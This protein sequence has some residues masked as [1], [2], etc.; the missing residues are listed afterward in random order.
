[1]NKDKFQEILNKDI[2][3][4]TD[5]EKEALKKILKELKESSFRG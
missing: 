2:S 3:L 4:L 5:S 1:M